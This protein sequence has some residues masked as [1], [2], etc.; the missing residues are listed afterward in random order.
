MDQE[1]VIN[2]KKKKIITKKR[3]ISTI[4]QLQPCMYNKICGFVFGKLRIKSKKKEC[5]GSIKGTFMRKALQSLM[6]KKLQCHFASIH[7]KNPNFSFFFFSFLFPG[8]ISFSLSHTHT[9]TH[10][11][12]MCINSIGP[13]AVYFSG[14]FS[15]TMSVVHPTLNTIYLNLS[16]LWGIRHLCLLCFHVF[17]LIWA[18]A[19]TMVLDHFPVALIVTY[20][21]IHVIIFVCTNNYL[22]D[23][24]VNWHRPFFTWI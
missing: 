5:K 24:A 8:T 15:L 17:I 13:K 20:I 12:Y 1:L 21:Y 23:V 14:P 6:I 22:L 3:K 10:T 4:P 7:Q 11:I 18:M 9:Y 2:V 16:I 19:Y